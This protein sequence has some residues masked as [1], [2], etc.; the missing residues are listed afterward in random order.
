MLSLDFEL[1]WGY[2]NHPEDRAVSLL[3]HDETRGRETTLALLNILDHFHLPATW[4]TVGSLFLAPDRAD[5]SAVD[6]ARLGVLGQAD[7]LLFH[8]PDLVDKVRNSP[9]RHEFGCHSFTH[10]R[11]SECSSNTAAYQLRESVR[12]AADLGIRLPSFVFPEN[13][14][15]HASLLKDEGFSIYRGRNVGGRGVEQGVGARAKGIV[16]RRITAPPVVPAW[17]NGLWEIPGSMLFGDTLAPMAVVPRATR[18]LRSA[19]HRTMLFHL[20]LHPQDLLLEPSLGSRL[21]TFLAT[22]AE[23]RERGQIDVLTMGELALRLTS[24]SHP[25]ESPATTEG[26]EE[27]GVSRPGLPQ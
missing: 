22:V 1:L 18:A 15:G 9:T 20:W 3:L 23:E 21:T 26:S 17:K 19:I 2:V 27:T 12:A 10:V 24:T 25:A 5:S 4:A 11:F 13:R 6:P 14:I 16:M 8:A 7:P